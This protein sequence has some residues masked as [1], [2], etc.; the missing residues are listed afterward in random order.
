MQQRQV[1]QPH[2]VEVDLHLGPVELGVVQSVA[3]RLVVDHRGVVQEAG[4][5]HA[6]SELAGE[7][8][9]AHDAEDEP[10][11]EAHQQHV[12][13]GRD[14]SQQSVH[15]HLGEGPS[16]PRRERQLV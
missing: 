7:Q 9:D 4:A 15:H 11:D 1:S 10:E 12:H 14:G 16:P 5:V 13:D 2:V 8:V 6:F 3:L